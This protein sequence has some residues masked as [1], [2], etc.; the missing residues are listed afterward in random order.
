[1]RLI[2]GQVP[3]G[4]L[5]GAAQLGHQCVA[6]ALEAGD[7]LELVEH[8]EERA[9]T[10]EAARAQRALV[11]VGIRFGVRIGVRCGVRF[12]LRFGVRVGLG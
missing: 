10:L 9:A 1:M 11:R 8:R 7:R 5:G 12:G 6:L 4:F 2:Q 3:H